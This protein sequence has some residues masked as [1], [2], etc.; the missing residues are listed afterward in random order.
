MPPRPIVLAIVLFWLATTGWLF[1]RDLWLL[2]RPGQPPPYTIDLAD[3]ARRQG[4]PISW[5]ILR[6]N[7]P[8]GAVSTS[9]HYQE[10]TD[11]FELRSETKE[12]DLGQAGPLRIQASQVVG[13]YRV[14]REGELRS[15]SA[16]AVLHVRGA[17]FLKGLGTE[18]TVHL[19]GEVKERQFTAQGYVEVAGRKDVLPLEPVEVS[20]RGSVLN[21]L[22]PLNRITGLRR[23]QHWTMPLVD[24]LGD[25]IAAMLQKNPVAEMILKRSPSVRMLRA[26][27]LPALQVL[28]WQH[29]EVPCL[30]IEYQGDELVAHTWVRESDGLVLRQEATV[31]GEQLTLERE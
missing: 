30:I 29:R 20:A 19:Q 6:D 7:K 31:W 10:A 14:T 15:M 26:E 27:V 13:T 11:T 12:L 17:G 22:H 4:F 18:A 5:Q 25:S 2:L 24:P 1:H 23:G 8:I 3:E 21:P 9:I 28:T 16:D